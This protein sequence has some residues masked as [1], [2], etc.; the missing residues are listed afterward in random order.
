MKIFLNS[1]GLVKNKIIL[2]LDQRKHFLLYVHNLY[3][4]ITSPLSETNDVFF[5]KWRRNKL[6]LGKQQLFQLYKT[7]KLWFLW[8]WILTVTSI[9][10]RGTNMEVEWS[11]E[12]S[13]TIIGQ[14]ESWRHLFGSFI[15]GIYLLYL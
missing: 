7:G 14:L 5:W 6:K 8:L 11:C 3:V 10:S 12:V 2:S 15:S 13:W 9:L 4:Y 1:S